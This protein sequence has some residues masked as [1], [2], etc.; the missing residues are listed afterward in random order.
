[1][2]MRRGAPLNEHHLEYAR[3]LV[4]ERREAFRR[5][6]FPDT[7]TS[8]FGSMRCMC[9]EGVAMALVVLIICAL[10]KLGEWTMQLTNVLISGVNHVAN[11]LAPGVPLWA[12]SAMQVTDEVLFGVAVA[13]IVI[14][15][16]CLEMLHSYWKRVSHPRRQEIEAVDER[17]RQMPIRIILRRQ[18]WRHVNPD[19][20]LPEDDA[21]SVAA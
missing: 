5:W 14:G 18:P 11:V 17:Y 7:D 21:A 6:V 15:L 12:K 3:H 8:L 10:S 1:M 9:I 13:G 19:N 2:P 4:Q 16:K 20:P